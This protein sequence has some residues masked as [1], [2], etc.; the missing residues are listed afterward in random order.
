[1]GALKG[2]SEPDDVGRLQ[3][4]LD[5]VTPADWKEL[6]SVRLRA[7]ANA[8]KA[9]VSEHSREAGWLEEDWRSAI[10]Q[11]RWVVAR[12]A[13]GVIGVARSSQDPESPERR[14]IEAVWVAP[15]FR[16]LGVGRRLVCWLIDRERKSEIKEM[17]LWVIDSNVNAQGFYFRMGF[18]ST[19]R[20]QPLPGREKRTE[21]LLA[22]VIG[23][24]GFRHS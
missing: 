12:T 8:P 1:M 20:I 19:G 3:V 5:W 10:Q 9:F 15:E 13:H 17:L 24:W 11:A 22:Y 18:R 14:Y 16:R 23:R 7:L 21:E 4:R 6:R 2:P